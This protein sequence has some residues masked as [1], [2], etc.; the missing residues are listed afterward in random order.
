MAQCVVHVC[1]CAQWNPYVCHIRL[2]KLLFYRVLCMYGNVSRA[3]T[4]H[5]LYCWL[6]KIRKTRP[7]NRLKNVGK[8][9]KFREKIAKFNDEISALLW[10]WTHRVSYPNDV[11]VAERAGPNNIDIDILCINAVFPVNSGTIQNPVNSRIICL[12]FISTSKHRKQK[13]FFFS[14]LLHYFFSSTFLVIFAM[15]WYLCDKY[16]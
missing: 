4:S 6:A 9:S 11:F 1:T 3:W 5:S 2:V 14:Y 16:C 8:L 10:L 12:M 15:E 7:R 13:H